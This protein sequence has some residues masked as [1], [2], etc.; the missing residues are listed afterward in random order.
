VTPFIVKNPP[1]SA[2]PS[3]R[4]A[5]AR[6]PGSASRSISSHH[7]PPARRHSWPVRGDSCVTRSS[8]AKEGLTPPTT[9][10]ASSR[11][12]RGSVTSRGA[13]WWCVLGLS[14]AAYAG[15]RRAG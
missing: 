14:A 13:N 1:L 9:H 3:R 15:L 10:R 4:R 2:H 7:H 6:M 5:P 12:P 11:A 8:R